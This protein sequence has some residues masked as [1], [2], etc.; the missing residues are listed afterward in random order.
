MSLP[1]PEGLQYLLLM[2]YERRPLMLHLDSKWV[3][4]C[5][6]FEHNSYLVPS[7][8]VELLV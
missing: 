2:S 6:F 4:Q 5:P 3:G 7:V 8:Y 1:E